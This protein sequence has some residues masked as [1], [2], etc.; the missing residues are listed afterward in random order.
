[1]DVTGYSINFQTFKQAITDYKQGNSLPIFHLLLNPPVT[2]HGANQP[3]SFELLLGGFRGDHIY[4]NDGP[5]LIQDL[6]GSDFIDGG[7]GND[8]IDDDMQEL[9]GIAGTDFLS[10]GDG[11]DVINGGGGKDFLSGGSGQ[12]E[13]DGGETRTPPITL[14]NSTPLLSP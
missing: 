6:G 11:A 10:G 8:R 3:Q 2:V 7:S 9:G 12:D 5:D 4:G 14:K 13:L 1:M